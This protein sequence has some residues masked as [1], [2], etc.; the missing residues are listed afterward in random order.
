MEALRRRVRKS[1]V[2][3]L[4]CFPLFIQVCVCLPYSSP[5][6]PL[7]SHL[8]ISKGSLVDGGMRR[9]MRARLRAAEEWVN[10]AD[11]SLCHRARDYRQIT[12]FDSLLFQFALLVSVAVNWRG[13]E[14]ARG[15]AGRGVCF[16]RGEIE[17][18]ARALCQGKMTAAQNTDLWTDSL[19]LMPP[20]WQLLQGLCLA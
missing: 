4:H 15:R 8:S 6:L 19:W 12:H 20:I 13:A 18:S 2:F 1:L 14:G 9:W 16:D 7:T 17:D 3:L 10:E 5:K 11:C